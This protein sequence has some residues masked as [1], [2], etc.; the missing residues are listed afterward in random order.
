MLER[1]YPEYQYLCSFAHGDSEAAFFRAVSDP[2]SALQSAVPSGQIEDFYQRQVLEMPRIYSAIAAVQAATEVAAIYP[3][4]ID[5]L[6][7]VTKAW[8]TLV[9]DSRWS[10]SRMLQLQ[11]NGVD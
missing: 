9:I 6:A 11:W 7:A 2:Q 5:L 1:L 10:A 8:A 4:Q 3:A